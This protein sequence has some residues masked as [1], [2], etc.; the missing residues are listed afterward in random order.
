MERY[1]IAYKRYDNYDCGSDEILTVVDN[2][3]DAINTL[4]AIVSDENDDLI[5]IVYY[6]FIRHTSMVLKPTLNSKLKLDLEEEK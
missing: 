1:L 5:S 3:K 6:D 2:R 4:S